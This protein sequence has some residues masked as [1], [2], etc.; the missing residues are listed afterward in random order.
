MRAKQEVRKPIMKVHQ[1]A[2]TTEQGIKVK[3][4]IKK[5]NLRVKIPPSIL[6]QLKRE[7]SR[8]PPFSNSLGGFLFTKEDPSLGSSF[9]IFLVSSSVFPL[10]SPFSFSLVSSLLFPSGSSFSN[11]SVSSSIFPLLSFAFGSS[12]FI[13]LFVQVLTP[14]LTWPDWEIS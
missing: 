11:F 5:E 10:R 12:L 13:A 6:N 9:S 1:R 8:R 7:R 3:V 4:A 2:V 14:L